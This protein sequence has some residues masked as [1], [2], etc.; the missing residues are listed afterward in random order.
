MSKWIDLHQHLYGCLTPQM[1]WDFGKANHQK[2]EGR[3]KWYE[4]EYFKA[5]GVKVD[6]AAYWSQKNGL[7]QLTDD[8]LVTKPV[9]F[10]VFQAKFN[11]AIAL[12]PLD[13]H[14]KEVLSAVTAHQHQQN[15]RYSEYRIPILESFDNTQAKQFI[16]DLIE[17]SL[18]I[19]GQYYD[20]F[21]FKILIS[22]PPNKDSML[23]K[24]QLLVE[25]Q[26]DHLDFY[27][28]IAGIDFC[29]FEETDLYYDKLKLI[30]Q[31]P[32][33]CYLHL[34]ETF[35]TYGLLQAYTR[36]AEGITKPV[37]RF[38]HLNVLGV[39]PTIDNLFKENHEIAFVE[40]W[41]KKHKSAADQ[42]TYAKDPLNYAHQLREE[43]LE[44][45]SVNKVVVESCP[46]SNLLLSGTSPEE[47][48]I[49]TFQKH[50]IPYVISTDDAGIFDTDMAKEYK[51]CKEI[52]GLADNEIAA[53][54]SRSLASM[55]P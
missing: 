21:S 10:A 28:V 22:M 4:A 30:D 26:Q 20:S 16:K 12:L 53:I 46:S 45:M 41:I 38:A 24:H 7:E 37:K 23:E 33:D 11:L 51:I 52:L 44:Y 43:I 18:E 47:H 5:M 31:S 39:E 6:S 15:Y 3:L 9:P 50:N 19:Q 1:L 29:Y 32:L 49:H 40:D 35:E 42:A 34:G 14:Y 2:Y 25:M 13:K 36:I 17:H 27:K 55:N 8:F 48:P 54:E